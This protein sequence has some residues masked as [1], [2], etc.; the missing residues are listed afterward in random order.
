MD[1]APESGIPHTLWGHVSMAGGFI[2]VVVMSWIAYYQ[3]AKE[4]K[5]K[6]NKI[7]AI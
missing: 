4:E 2:Y 6:Q 5:E 3:C 7:Q 1:V